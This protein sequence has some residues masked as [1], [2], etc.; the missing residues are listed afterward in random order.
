MVGHARDFHFGTSKIEIGGDDEQV[1]DPCGQDFLRNRSIA[2]ER[3]INAFGVNFL[4][5]ER[6]GRICLRIEIN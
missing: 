3:F 5:A 2:D 4:H 1:V 6:A